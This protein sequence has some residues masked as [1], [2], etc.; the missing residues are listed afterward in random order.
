MLLCLSSESLSRGKALT[1]SSPSNSIN[2]NAIILS[3]NSDFSNPRYLDLSERKN[4]SFNLKPGK[5]YWKADNFI[6]EG[7]KKEFTI[8]SEVGLNIN[9]VENRTDLVNIGN[10]KINITKDDEGIIV[11]H[12]ILGPEESEKIEDSGEYTGRQT[13]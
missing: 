8:E 2:A 7:L 13:E 6:I 1:S 4:I 5:Y 3:E 12:V 11:G 9:R 10:V